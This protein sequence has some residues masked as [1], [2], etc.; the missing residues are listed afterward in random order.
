[1]R[2]PENREE[3]YSYVAFENGTIYKRTPIGGKDDF[4]ENLP[5]DTKCGDCGGHMG[6]FHR[7]N[8]DCERDPRTGDQ[9]LSSDEDYL[10]ISEQAKKEL[11]S[12]ST[13]TAIL[14]MAAGGAIVGLGHLI[15][16]EIKNWKR[17]CKLAQLYKQEHGIE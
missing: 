9:L 12:I 11:T 1:M 3:N 8:C 13:S 7:Y 16:K 6:D 15:T 4:Y 10:F 17:I 2:L 5:S 14:L